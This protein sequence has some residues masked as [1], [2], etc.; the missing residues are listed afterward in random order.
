MPLTDQD[1]ARLYNDAFQQNTKGMQGENAFLALDL[2]TQ[3]DV[4]RSEIGVLN[5]ELKAA[6]SELATLKTPKPAEAVVGAGSAGA[7]KT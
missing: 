1:R 3:L 2:K 7:A 4:A 6:Q 5:D